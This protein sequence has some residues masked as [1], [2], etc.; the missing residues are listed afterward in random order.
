MTEYFFSELNKKF[1]SLKEELAESK[2]NE[3]TVKNELNMMKKKGEESPNN[4]RCFYKNLRSFK[5]LFS[6]MHLMLKKEPKEAREKGEN[7]LNRER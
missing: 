6:V 5:V 4:K 3:Q 1:S 7:A 2:E